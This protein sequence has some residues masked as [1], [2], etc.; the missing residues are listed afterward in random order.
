MAGSWASHEGSS[1][2]GSSAGKWPVSSVLTCFPNGWNASFRPPAIPGHPFARASNPR[3]GLGHGSDDR[4]S[5]TSSGRRARQWGAVRIPEWGRAAVG[6]VDSVPSA[7][8]VLGRGGLS[9]SS[10]F[11]HLCGVGGADRAL[12]GKQHPP[13]QTRTRAPSERLVRPA[14]ALPACPPQAIAPTHRLGTGRSPPSS[15]TASRRTEDVSPR[16]RAGLPKWPRRWPTVGPRGRGQTNRVLVM[17]GE[18]PGGTRWGPRSP[19]CRGPQILSSSSR[20]GVEGMALRGCVL[21]AYACRVHRWDAVS[22]S[23]AHTNSKTLGSSEGPQGPPPHT[24]S[25]T[26]C[27]DHPRRSNFGRRSPQPAPPP[28]KFSPSGRGTSVTAVWRLHHGTKS[29]SAREP[30]FHPG[31]RDVR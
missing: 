9:V 5:Y 3:A 10:A 15:C 16:Q 1:W 24:T 11:G 18:V 28:E 17:A 21:R 31:G 23:C 22:S 26:P 4:V 7:A 2:L 29:P 25:R 19:I 6:F 13:H 14:E 8:V 27:H 30:G 20:E 12:V